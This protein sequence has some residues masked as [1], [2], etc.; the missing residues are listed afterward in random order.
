MTHSTLTQGHAEY[1]RGMTYI[2]LIVVLGIFSVLSSVAIYNYG[3][4][5]DKVDIKNLASDIALKIVKAQKASLSGQLPKVAVPSNWKPAYG[6]YFKLISPGSNKSLIYF[7]DVDQGY[8]YDDGTFCASPGTGE[9]VEKI[10]ITKGNVISDLSVYYIGN[11][12]PTSLA[13]SD[14]TVTFSRIRSG[15]VFQSSG[16]LGANIDYVQISILSPRGSTSLVK[17]YPSGR[18]QIN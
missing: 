8:D 7:A 17:I 1:C 12:T 14:L 10:N 15:G 18:V 2:E 6:V 3:Q 4:F 16:S 11:P 5:Q 9:C 13:G